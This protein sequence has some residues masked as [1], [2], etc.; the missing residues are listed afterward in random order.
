MRARIDLTAGDNLDVSVI[1]DYW[2][3]DADCCIWTLRSIGTP[4]SAGELEQIAIGARFGEENDTQNID[5]GVFSDVNTGG[6]SVQADYRF[7]NGHTFTSI[8]AYRSWHTVD[9]LDTDN[10]PVNTF[11][12]NFA[13]F[14]QLLYTQEFRITSPQE[15]FIDYVAGAFYYY[16]D[17]VSES[18]QLQPLLTAASRTA[19]GTWSPAPRTWR[20]SA[21][22]T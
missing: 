1:A 2:K 12:V 21:R 15:Q 17:V 9:G 5:G 20:S 22:R 16:S 18:R 3:R 6:I 14:K 7:G 13:D 8:S 10:R 4:A 11:N 19:S